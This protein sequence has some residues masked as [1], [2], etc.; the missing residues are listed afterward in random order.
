MKIYIFITIV[1]ITIMQ[2]ALAKIKILNII[3]PVTRLKTF[4]PY[5]VIQLFLTVTAF[6]YSMPGLMEL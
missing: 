5:L 6:D 2:P 3:K 1:F 4:M